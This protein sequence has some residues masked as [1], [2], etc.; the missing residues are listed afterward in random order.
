MHCKLGF[1]GDEAGYDIQKQISF[2]KMNHL[3]SIHVRSVNGKLLNEY[4]TEVRKNIFDQI[5]QQE[6]HVDCVL[7]KIGKYPIADQMQWAEE[8]EA[9]IQIC[10]SWK[11]RYLRIFGYGMEHEEVVNKM[12]SKARERGIMIL[13][14]N[15]T[16]TP[17]N[18][19]EECTW[20]LEKYDYKMGLLLD[21]GNLFLEH[22]DCVT[23][24]QKLNKHIF[25]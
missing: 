15:E 20:I 18:T 25:I 16:N 7:S 19:V 22:G 10:E 13:I 12:V 24:Y 4:S 6:I 21:V 1:I 2:C 17:M 5:E 11:S 23:F 9:Y 14:E 8:M 3:K